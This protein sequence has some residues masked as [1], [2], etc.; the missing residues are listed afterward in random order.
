MSLTRA[1]LIDEAV[2]FVAVLVAFFAVLL[3]LFWL[4]AI[5]VPWL[6]RWFWGS[7]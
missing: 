2:E 1:Q 7:D 4:G 3:G 6:W 5:G